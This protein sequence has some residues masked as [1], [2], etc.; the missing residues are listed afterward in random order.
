MDKLVCNRLIFLLQKL[1]CLAKSKFPPTMFDSRL[2]VAVSRPLPHRRSGRHDHRR[3]PCHDQ[4][5]WVRIPRFNFGI[6]KMLSWWKFWS[7]A[8]NGFDRMSEWP[9]AWPTLRGKTTKAWINLLLIKWPY[10]HLQ[11]YVRE[12]VSSE[13]FC[14]TLETWLALLFETKI[15]FVYSKCLL[16]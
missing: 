2:H 3:Q 6:R 10:W 1:P 5:R 4:Q 15:A 8:L 11:C 9:H 14:A 16:R 12:E 7:L 13:L